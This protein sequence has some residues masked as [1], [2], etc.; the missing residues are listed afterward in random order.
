ME[1]NEDWKKFPCVIG[2]SNTR[3]WY[4]RKFGKLPKKVYVCHN[5]DQPSCRQIEHI[6]L[7]SQ[8]DNMKDCVNK[9]RFSQHNK[10]VPSPM[11]G[12]PLTEKTKAKLSEN[13]SFTKLTRDEVIEIKTNL[14]ITSWELSKKFNV[15]LITIERIRSGKTW[16]HLNA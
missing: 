5:C 13:S 16:R 8:S 6:F 2:P 14:E 15:N 7:G 11:K 1:L 3:Y 12:I 4:Q 10:G 9:G